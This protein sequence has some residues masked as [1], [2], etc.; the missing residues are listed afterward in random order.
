MQVEHLCKWLGEATREV[1][2]DATHWEKVMKILQT[3]FHNGTLAQEYRWH[4]VV[5]ILKGDRRVQKGLHGYC[6]HGF[7]MEVNHRHNQSETHLCDQ[8]PQHAA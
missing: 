3:T 7:I 1:D 2:T 5:L 8:I 6:N 4:T